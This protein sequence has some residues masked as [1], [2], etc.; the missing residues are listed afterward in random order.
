MG[1]CTCAHVGTPGDKAGGY[2]DGI[3]DT[4][5][6]GLGV[7]MEGQEWGQ[8]VAWGQ[9][10]GSTGTGMEMGMAQGWGQGDISRGMGDGPGM[11]TTQAG[12]QG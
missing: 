1:S 5:G 4:A 3:G 8:R 2:R 12:Q 11:G 9:G 6:T 7:G 10:Q